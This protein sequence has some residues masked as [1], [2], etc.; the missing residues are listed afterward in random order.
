VSD[1]SGGRS[2]IEVAGGWWTR[3]AQIP[4]GLPTPVIVSVV[5]MIVVLV[6][7]G[8]L[9]LSNSQATSLI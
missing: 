6:V 3:F 7:N 8:W 2:G 4:F 9:L 1:T 5:V